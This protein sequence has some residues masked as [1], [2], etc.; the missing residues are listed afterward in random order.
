MTKTTRINLATDVY[1]AATSEVDPAGKIVKVSFHNSNV[2]LS[3][4][5]G[6]DFTDG[7]AYAKSDFPVR[8]ASAINELLKAADFPYGVCSKEECKF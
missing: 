6:E 3:Y 8:V 1:V 2:D 4:F 7:E 5:Y